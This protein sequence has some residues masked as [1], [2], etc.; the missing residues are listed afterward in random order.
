MVKSGN[1]FG[2]CIVAKMQINK[3]IDFLNKIMY[4]MTM[5]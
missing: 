1:Q 5:S 2:V 3:T 4:I